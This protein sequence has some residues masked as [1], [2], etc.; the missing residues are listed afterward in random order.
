MVTESTS[1]AYDIGHIASYCVTVILAIFPA[2]YKVIQFFSSGD[3]YRIKISKSDTNLNIIE[4]LIASDTKNSTKI[5]T[6]ESKEICSTIVEE[7]VFHIQTGCKVDKVNFYIYRAVIG[8]TGLKY[9]ACFATKV[10]RPGKKLGDSC[11]R[12]RNVLCFVTILSILALGI[13]S[14]LLGVVMSKSSSPAAITLDVKQLIEFYFIIFLQIAFFL[15]YF[16]SFNRA[17][18]SFILLNSIN[19]TDALKQL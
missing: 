3:F 10:S 9:L 11:R 12:S 18:N 19:K 16:A 14:F 1:A 8:Y 7:S 17:V 15:L 2:I 4:K 6:Q 13:L 5:I